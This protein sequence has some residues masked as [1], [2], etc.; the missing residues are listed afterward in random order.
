MVDKQK[1]RELK[2]KMKIQELENELA[3]IKETNNELVKYIHNLYTVMDIKMTS[4]VETL[5]NK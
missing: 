2:N 1:L 3:S 4:E 5:L